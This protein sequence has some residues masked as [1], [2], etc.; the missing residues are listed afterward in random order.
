MITTHIHAHRHA[1]SATVDRTQDC[2]K[3]YSQELN[4]TNG[5]NHIILLMRWNID[6]V[7][8]SSVLKKGTLTEEEEEEAHT[9][10]IHLSP[11]SCEDMFIFH[12]LHGDS[13]VNRGHSAYGWNA[14]SGFTGGASP[15]RALLDI[16]YGDENDAI[17][18]E[19]PPR[20][21]VPR[22]RG[23]LCNSGQAA[24]TSGRWQRSLDIARRV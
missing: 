7:R 15:T 12:F 13:E 19:A 16:F 24:V 22:A 1:H 3:H 4:N 21:L 11:S 18:V 20:W 14:A 9:R 10:M 17:Y 2:N 5:P 23:F 6:T 8:T